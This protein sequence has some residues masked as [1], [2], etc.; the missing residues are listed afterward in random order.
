MKRLLVF[1]SFLILG[2]NDALSQ[3]LDG[4][5]RGSFKSKIEAIS[6]PPIPI[7]LI[8]IRNADS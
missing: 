3:S 5:W 7:S 8:I 1:I 2:D 6:I 4:L